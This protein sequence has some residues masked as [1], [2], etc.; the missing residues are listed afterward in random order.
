MTTVN[1]A[2]QTE[3]LRVGFVGC[4]EHARMSLYPSLRAAFGGSPSGLP[5]L[6]LTQEGRTQP[7]LLAEL[8]ALADHKRDLAERVAA[9]HGVRR[10]LHRP[11]RDA[12]RRAA[13]RRDRLHAPPAPGAGGDRLP[14]SAAST[15]GWRSRPAESLRRG[16]TRWPRPP[17][18]PGKHARRGLHEALL[19]SLPAGEGVRRSS[20]PFG[21]PSVYEAR[22]TYGAVPG[23]RLPLPQRLRDP[24]P[25]P[26]ALLHGRGRIGLRRARQPGQGAATATPSPCASPTAGVGLIN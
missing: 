8:V 22:F 26:A 19:L 11:P 20:R 14:A 23:R 15:S 10:R 21:T 13:G 16:A 24:P 2:E 5:A 1:S 18:G 6:V 9:F 25:R 3:P 17:G 4:G 7:P 12:G